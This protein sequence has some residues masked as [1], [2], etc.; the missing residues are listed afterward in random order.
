[1]K[2]VLLV[3]LSSGFAAAAAAQSSV[4]LYGVADA[5]VGQIKS[6]ALEGG[7]TGVQL[8]SSSA[9]NNDTTKLGVRG[10]ED[11]GGGLKSGF[12]LE[13]GLS[14]GDGSAN[15]SGGQFWSRAANLWLSGG[16]GRVML[17]RAH[18]PTR[19]TLGVWE[20][21]DVANYSVVADTYYQDTGEGSRNSSQMRYTTPDVAGLR[22]DVAYVA[23]DN[24]V[25]GQRPRSK[26]DLGLTYA[27]GPVALGASANKQAGG[28][29]NFEMGGKYVI[30]H[31][32]G[33][34]LALA[35]SYDDMTAA[36]FDGP[37][38]PSSTVA[39]RGFS[40]GGRYLAGPVTVTVDLTRDTEN[41]TD[42][43]LKKYTNALLEGEYALS[44]R[45]FLYAAYLRLDGDNNY[46]IG[47]HHA[48]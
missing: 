43:D 2:R 20:L 19:D 15:L 11:L 33:G 17:G 44:K 35:A 16:W 42:V 26:W 22:A 5:G 48:F 29:T 3:V 10:V 12:D 46:G 37:G 39:R 34:Q 14:L 1:M 23:R 13:D 30:E 6:P 32:A 28:R 25:T 9:L 36:T 27:N 21:T 7:A 18:T 4:T 31:A 40:L 8:L 38:D 24:N 47:M 45:T 41:E